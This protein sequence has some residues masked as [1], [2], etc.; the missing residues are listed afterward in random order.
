MS[1]CGCSCRKHCVACSCYPEKY[2]DLLPPSVLWSRL[3]ISSM[4]KRCKGICKT[5]KQCS[6]TDGSSMLD[7]YGRFVA[8]PLLAGCDACIFH[9]ETFVT[10]PLARTTSFVGVCFDLETTGLSVTSD[11]IVE[12][13]A[14]EMDSGAAFGVVVNP[15]SSFTACSE[16]AVHGIQKAELEKG[17]TF[18]SAYE[19]FMSFLQNAID[20]AM[21]EDSN[22][23]DEPSPPRLK[24]ERPTLLLVAHNGRKFDFPFLIAEC[25]R[26]SLTISADFVFVDTLTISQALGSPCCKLQCLVHRLT[27][28]DLRPHRAT[29]DCF[30]LRQV[31]IAMSHTLG[32][33]PLQLLRRFAE[34]CD[35]DKT[36]A[37]LCA[38]GISKES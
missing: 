14:V 23:D 3:I 20:M 19:Q 22:S 36:T 18:K 13:G 33:E 6:I 10:K 17:F 15:G 28:S 37:N 4:S 21:S 25:A 1:L 9:L 16:G 2:V 38:I 34:G 24:N 5:G 29:E 30:T 27:R 11:R 7:S 32:I 12:I 26:N 31:C 35:V 8:A